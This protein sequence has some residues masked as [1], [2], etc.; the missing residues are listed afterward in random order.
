M[1]TVVTATGS[2]Y[3]NVDMVINKLAVSIVDS[4]LY[5][6]LIFFFTHSTT[7]QCC[8]IGITHRTVTINTENVRNGMLSTS[9]AIYDAVKITFNK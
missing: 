2:S 4:A 7:H 3:G 9:Q 5:L 1:V 6:T 8:L